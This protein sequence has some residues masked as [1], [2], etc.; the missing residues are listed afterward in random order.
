MASQPK[1]S[2][3]E[4]LMESPFSESLDGSL[5]N[6]LVETDG[7]TVVK[8]F[9]SRPKMAYVQMLGRI[10]SGKFE[11]QDRA[12]R[13][14]N[15]RIFRNYMED[16]DVYI[17]DILRVEDNFVEF[18][19]VEGEDMN[20]YLNQASPSEAYEAGKLAGDFLYQLHDEDAA[21]T[22]L[23]INNFMMRDIGGL[24]FVDA[25]YF[26]EDATDWEKQMDFITLA[27]SAKQVEPEA[28]KGF[29][30][31]FQ[32][33]YGDIRLSS[34]MISSITA[35]GHAVLLEQD[36]DRLRNSAGNIRDDAENYLDHFLN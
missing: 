35:P 18:E 28:Y 20:T 6:E 2:S 13:I 29:R 14:E 17:P 10:P 5:T 4:E 9:S 3:L 23:R 15:E 36:K 19:K 21:I 16:M 27:S 11:F 31:G 24:A 22:D 25:E 34:D 8:K 7:G 12:S 33:S 32:E 1:E 30:E 26:S